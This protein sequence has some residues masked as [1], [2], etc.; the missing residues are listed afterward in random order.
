[1]A[2]VIE[3][4]QLQKNLKE[5][6]T[7]RQRLDNLIRDV[8]VNKF[9]QDLQRTTNPKDDKMSGVDEKI[10]EEHKEPRRIVT[11]LSPQ[12]ARRSLGSPREL[13]TRTSANTSDEER[14][15]VSKS[16]AGNSSIDT[17]RRDQIE[18]KQRRSSLINDRRQLWISTCEKNIMT[19]PVGKRVIKF[20]I[21]K[22]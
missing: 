4:E 16:G 9:Q 22:R 15:Q 17:Q 20:L 2:F 3:R 7:E 12:R 8:V 6:E 11:V 14:L 19:D 21:Y 13:M 1:M 5:Q 18:R 10:M